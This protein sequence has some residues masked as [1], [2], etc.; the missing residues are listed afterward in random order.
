M[1][2]FIDV[3]GGD[4]RRRARASK[5]LAK[6][7]HISFDEWNVWYITVPSPSRP[8]GDDWPVAPVLL[9]DHYNVA[10]AVVVGS[11]LISPA[12]PHRPGARGVASR[13]SST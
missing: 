6:R 1:D 5:K 3:G 10:D 13:S 11:L 4:R 12:A 9:E 7:I 8:T 2:H